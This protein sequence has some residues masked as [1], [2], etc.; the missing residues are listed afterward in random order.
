MEIYMYM[1]PV[2]ELAKVHVIYNSQ[3]ILQP[4]TFT[5][6]SFIFLPFKPVSTIIKTLPILGTYF[7]L[8]YGDE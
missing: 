4:L 6:F 5:L 8:F 1:T 2:S 7:C 3:W